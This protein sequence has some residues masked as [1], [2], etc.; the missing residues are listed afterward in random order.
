MVVV[1]VAG[2]A[3]T[4]AVL[5]LPDP[6]GGLTDEAQALAA[7][8]ATARDLAIVGGRDIAVT[9]DSFGYG[10]AERGADGWTP[11]KAPALAARRWRDGFSAAASIDSGGRLVFD[12]TGVATPARIVLR[13]DDG[14]ASVTVMG[15]GEVASDA[16]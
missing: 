6:R 1:F 2:L 4:I 8:L 10:F 15:N 7:R 12:T 11:M 5:A 9:I 16:R 3:T 14:E 13:R